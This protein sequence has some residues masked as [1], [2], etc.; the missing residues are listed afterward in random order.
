M[1]INH[2][3]LKE[4]LYIDD[5]LITSVQRNVLDRWEELFGRPSKKERLAAAKS[6]TAIARRDGE[7]VEYFTSI[8]EWYA[9]QQPLHPISPAEF[10]GP[11]F[12]KMARR[13]GVR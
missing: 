2:G 10:F 1:S 4:R 8:I 9:G 13:A 6:I 12:Q 5:M 7:D 11:E 3:A